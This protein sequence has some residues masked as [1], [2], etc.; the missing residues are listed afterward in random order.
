MYIL[1][2]TRRFAPTT[3]EQLVEQ[4][5][6]IRE[7]LAQYLVPQIANR[8]L[9][10]CL[11]DLRTPPVDSLYYVRPGLTVAGVLALLDRHLGLL[12][13]VHDLKAPA[14]VLLYLTLGTADSAIAHRF[15]FEADRQAA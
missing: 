14:D 10:G 13:N 1:D 9:H 4:L 8:P 12:R 7:D 11:I 2:F 15:G 5:G 3:K 6:Q